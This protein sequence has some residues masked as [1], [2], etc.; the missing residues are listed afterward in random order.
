MAKEC[1]ICGKPIGAL[2]SRARLQDGYVCGKCHTEMVG[3]SILVTS[4]I[5]LNQYAKC[6]VEEFPVKAKEVAM[7]CSQLSSGQNSFARNISVEK[8]I[9]AVYF[10]DNAKQFTISKPKRNKSTYRYD[11][12]V[13]FEL[14]EDG[15]TVAKSGLGRAVAGGILFGGV[16]AIVGG[17]TGGRTSKDVCKS[18]QIKITLKN[19]TIPAEYIKFIDF[20]TKKSGSIYQAEIKTAQDTMSA[21]QVAVDMVGG[22]A[23]DPQPAQTGISAADEIRKYK[24]LLDDGIITEEEF[25]AKKK[26]LLGL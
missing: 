10:D 18:L 15:A 11:Q 6:T 12:I 26:Q 20:E 14:L 13:D 25:S 5:Y 9:G 16:G 23:P 8:K 4:V 3:Q 21:L 22:K 17:I 19:S 1:S 24:S 2:T 7:K